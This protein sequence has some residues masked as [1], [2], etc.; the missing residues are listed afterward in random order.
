MIQAFAANAQAHRRDLPSRCPLR[1]WRP[2]R[3]RLQTAPG[4]WRRPAMHKNLQHK[5]H[6][7]HWASQL[8]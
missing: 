1:L 6:K 4:H 3:R 8:L 5:L 2:L 7:R